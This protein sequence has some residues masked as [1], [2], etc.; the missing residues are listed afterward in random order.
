MPRN[1]SCYQ[2]CSRMFH[3][4]ACAELMGLASPRWGPSSYTTKCFRV[5]QD[6]FQDRDGLRII[7]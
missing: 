1:S 7:P 3:P 2:Q 6:V 4:R 5:S